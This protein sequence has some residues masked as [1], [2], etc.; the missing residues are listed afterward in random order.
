MR[1]GSREYIGYVQV[2]G[3]WLRRVAFTLSG[4]WY[5]GGD[6]A[7]NTLIQLYRHWRRIDPASVDAYDRRVLVNL[8]LAGE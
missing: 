2:C 5:T 8:Y 4:D 1:H 6:L 3:L 7:Q